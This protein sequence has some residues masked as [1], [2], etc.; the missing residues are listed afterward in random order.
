MQLDN[1]D[2]KLKVIKLRHEGLNYVKIGEQVG[3]GKTAVGNFLTR[4]T[5]KDWWNAYDAKPIASG[6]LNHHH[7][8]VTK[9]TRK[10]YICTSAQ[11]NT[12]VH[13][14]FLAS[15]KV[16]ANKLDAQILVGTFSYNLSGFQN[17]AKSAGWFDPAIREYI[18]DE[19]IQ[20][21]DGLMWFGEL[22]ILPTAATPL[23]GFHSYGRDGSGIIPHVK[24]QM[25]S[26]PYHKGK[27]P[28]FLYT[29]GCV[30]QRNYIEKKAGQKAAFHHVFGALIVEVDS[31]GDWFV[32][33]I[34]AETETGCFY[35]LDVYYAPDGYTTGN[36][37]EAI[38]YGDI[39]AESLDPVVAEVSFGDVDT[40][41]LNS[42]WPTYQFVHDGL[43]FKSRNHH[44]IND[45]YY[46]FKTH[47]T[48]QDAVESDIAKFTSV[49]R[50]MYR[51]YSFV[52][53]VE[54]NHDLALR[55]W[56]STA[57]YKQDPANALFFLRCQLATYEAIAKGDTKFS[58]LEHVAR[59]SVDES[60]TFLR[61]DESFMICDSIECGQ[62]GH[63]GV[64]GARGSI[65]GYLRLGT[66]HN[67]GHSHSAGIRD[68][69]Y[70]AGVSAKLDLGYNSG[71]TTWSHSHIITY[72][73]GKRAI[74]TIKR[75]KWRS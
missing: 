33:Q 12:H 39:H 57:D 22:N 13:P 38:N 37:I 47:I 60:V 55:K 30:T 65:N 41:I 24:M 45:P 54:S 48:G 8:E 23:S 56:L 40:S 4:T 14:N 64:N 74:I 28:R 50:S 18:R 25:E 69:V 43:D 29:T 27:E 53:V 6:K 17:M 71:G 16:M 2:V 62:H 5:H 42:L 10:Y 75:G 20:L 67:I 66:R 73:N 7:H 51:D 32:R 68:G 34:C 11:N 1:D 31:D 49:L 59:G 15:L 44:N 61:T 70:Q 58:I 9:L 72:Q 36:N 35:D 26:V 63:L 46:R 52:V 21:A 19:P 3:C